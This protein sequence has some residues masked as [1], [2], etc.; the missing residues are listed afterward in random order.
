MRSSE[1]IR[2]STSACFSCAVRRTRGKQRGFHLDQSALNLLL[3]G[4]FLELSPAFNLMTPLWNSFVREAIAPAIV[5]FTG[6]LKPWHGPMF[7]LDHRL[8]LASLLLAQIGVIRA[9]VFFSRR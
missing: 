3:R 7:L 9:G 5:H 1:A 4:D 8:A 2:S 6:A